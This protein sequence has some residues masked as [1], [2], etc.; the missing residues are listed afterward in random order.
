MQVRN[1]TLTAALLRVSRTLCDDRAGGVEAPSSDPISGRWKSALSALLIVC[2]PR[3]ASG[4]KA[5]LNAV[6]S[7]LY[8]HTVS[9]E[10]HHVRVAAAGA[11]ASMG[12][13]GGTWRNAPFWTNRS[14]C[15]SRRDDS[16]A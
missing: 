8:R 5:A 10:R 11:E 6:E 12:A 16:S 3:W 14:Y 1:L 7:C 4:S 15:T 2:S 9:C 13:I